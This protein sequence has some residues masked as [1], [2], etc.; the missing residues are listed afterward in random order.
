MDGAGVGALVS[1]GSDLEAALIADVVSDS[2]SGVGFVTGEGVEGLAAE[3]I[4]PF[5]D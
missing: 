5:F 2:I 4:V 1:P 3:A